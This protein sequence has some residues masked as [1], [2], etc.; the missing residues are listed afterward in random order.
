MPATIEGMFLMYSDIVD[1]FS[2][3]H[4]SYQKLSGMYEAARARMEAAVV[5]DSATGATQVDRAA[6]RSGIEAMA[7]SPSD[8]QLQRMAA[9]LERGFL[10]QNDKLAVPASMLLDPHLASQI[11]IRAWRGFGFAQ[12]SKPATPDAMAK[13]I[14]AVFPNLPDPV[15]AQKNMQRLIKAVAF[16]QQSVD[17]YEAYVK[18]PAGSLSGNRKPNG[19]PY[20]AG[21]KRG[22]SP[23]HTPKINSNPQVNDQPPSDPLFQGYIDAATCLANANWTMHWY[24][25]EIC[26]DAKCADA[27]QDVLVGSNWESFLLA[28]WQLSSKVFEAVISGGWVGAVIEA[29]E[30]YWGIMIAANKTPNGVCLFIPGPWTLGLM[31]PGWAVGR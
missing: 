10:M 5:V 15:A 29:C 22:V 2:E 19:G 20:D 3:V 11:D 16:E 4:G 23:A 18:L 13:N 21:T 25:P 12:P 30:I 26:L 1:V 24:G 6:L 27:I 31:G 28:F 8:Q 7:P 9:G 14:R 17:A